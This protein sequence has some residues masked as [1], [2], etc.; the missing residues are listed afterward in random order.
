[1]AR[2][3]AEH[4]AA[5]LAAREVFWGKGYDETSVE[6]L[7][8]AT[9][10]NRYAL[11]S[12]FGG[13]LDLFLA[14]LDFYQEERRTMF[15]GFLNDDTYSPMEAVERVFEFCCDEMAKR[16]VGCL[17]GNIAHNVARTEPRVAERVKTHFNEIEDAHVEA[18]GRAARR[19]ELN[20]AVSP[21]DGAKVIITLI[22]GLGAGV[23]NIHTTQDSRTSFRTA[24]KALSASGATAATGATQ[25]KRKK[26]PA[27]PKPIQH[28]K[29]K[30][31]R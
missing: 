29:R 4:R 11:Y 17:L 8:A 20:P 14:V 28:S 3:E 18:L 24:L 27:N 31:S 2:S 6:D 13:K 19:G 9:G 26:T 25:R 1:M 5:L 22:L 10:L 7:V 16:G 12:M 23:E 15:K 30:A 21:E